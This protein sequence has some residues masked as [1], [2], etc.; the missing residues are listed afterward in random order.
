MIS[1]CT[2]NMRRKDFVAGGSELKSW[3]CISEL[4]AGEIQHPQALRLSLQ[5][6]NIER[7]CFP[8]QHENNGLHRI[9]V[10]EASLSFLKLP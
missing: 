8:Q 9:I 1:L 2:I 4:A 6:A 7:W 10:L 3:E 5:L